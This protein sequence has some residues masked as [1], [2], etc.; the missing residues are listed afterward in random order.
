MAERGIGGANGLSAELEARAGWYRGER[1]G[2]VWEYRKGP[3][4]GRRMLRGEGHR[5]HERRTCV[6]RWNSVREDRLRCWI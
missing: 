3:G 5:A 6:L 1:E 4:T 2:A